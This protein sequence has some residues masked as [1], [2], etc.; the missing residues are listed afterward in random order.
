MMTT[1][2]RLVF[3]DEMKR[4]HSKIM[5][6]PLNKEQLTT[7]PKAIKILDF[8][9]FSFFLYLPVCVAGWSASADSYRVIREGEHLIENELPYDSELVAWY[10]WG[11][12][13]WI[14]QVKNR[15]SVQSA[16]KGGEV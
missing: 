5:R 6:D 15:L 7:E 16:I 11:G 8:E 10:G 3:T 4:V 2:N 1:I 12:S 9:G 13:G 14:A